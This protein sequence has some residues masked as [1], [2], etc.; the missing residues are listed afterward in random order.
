MLGADGGAT[1]I[2]YDLL[3][4]I[5]QTSDSVPSTVTY[6]Y[7]HTAEPR[8]MATKTTDSVAGACETAY[9]AN[10]NGTN[11]RRLY[12]LAFLEHGTRRPH[13]TGVTAHPTREWTVQQARI[14]SA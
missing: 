5:T 8:G 7:D 9:E 3:N 12:A 10:G 4:R 1:Q 13:I 11:G 6:T 14:P 2:R